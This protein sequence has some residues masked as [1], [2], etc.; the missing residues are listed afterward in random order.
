MHAIR[1]VEPHQPLQLLDLPDPVP[2]AGEIVVD[3]Q[4]AGICHTDAH[5]RA[6]TATMDLPITLG[7]EIAGVVSAVG[8]G[9]TDVREG[10]R[11]ALHYL[12]SC[13]ECPRCKRHGEQ[14]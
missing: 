8:D 6:G 7:H 12:T 10:Q 4:R 1:L 3:I 13:G 14:F 9:V 11:V 2:A 5:Y